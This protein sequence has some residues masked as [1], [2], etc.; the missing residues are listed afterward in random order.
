MNAAEYDI[1][2]LNGALGAVGTGV[3]PIVH[4]D[5]YDRYWSES[6]LGG[7]NKPLTRS[8]DRIP[9]DRMTDQTVSHMLDIITNTLSQTR[10]IA[11]HLEGNTIAETAKN[12]Y[13]YFFRHYQYVEDAGAKE[14]LRSPLRAYMD[15]EYG[16]DCDCFVISISSIL[17]NLGIP[18]YIRRAAYDGADTDYS[19][20]Y[21]VVPVTPGPLN[22]RDS[23]IVIDPVVHEFDFEYPSDTTPGSYQDTKVSVGLGGFLNGLGDVIY[24]LNPTL[25]LPSLTDL[26]FSQL[27]SFQP[28]LDPAP[29]EVTSQQ[30]QADLVTDFV[31]SEFTDINEYLRS[32]Q[33]Q[34]AIPQTQFTAEDAYQYLL[35]YQLNQPPLNEGSPDAIFDFSELERR[36]ASFGINKNIVRWGLI[37]GAGIALLSVLFSN[38]KSPLIP[39]NG[40][41]GV[42]GNKTT[43]GKTGQTNQLLTIKM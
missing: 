32:L 1:E 43:G 27:Y 10:A 40:M 25:T 26:Q 19:H 34:D 3:R 29:T 16:V 8:G 35:N 13:N 38:K 23:Y 4:T 30:I 11:T 42:S 24:S 5:K 17:T 33:L 18:H 20:V 9:Y 2:Y 6:N 39:A 12:I 21:V 41:E 7:E 36:E 37:G 22:V 28:T 15:R 31:D 14:Q